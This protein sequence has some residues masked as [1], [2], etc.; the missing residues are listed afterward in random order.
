MYSYVPNS[1]VKLYGGEVSYALVKGGAA[2]PAIGIRG[3]YTK[4]TGVNDLDL[5]TYGVDASISK[6]ILFITPYVGAGAVYIDSKAKGRLNTDP[7][8]LLANGGKPLSEEK[9]WQERYFG[10]IELKP[11]P[12][13]RLVAEAEYSDRP[14]YSAKIS[15]GF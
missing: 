11:F 4:L 5:Q 3:T 15:I 12:F 1:N 7:I 8:F 10:G 13:F 6:G 9:F 14:V 2:L